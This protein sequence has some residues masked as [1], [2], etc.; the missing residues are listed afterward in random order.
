MRVVAI[1]TLGAVAAVGAAVAVAPVRD[2]RPSAAPQRVARPI[3]TP[4]AALPPA[5]PAEAPLVVR[6]I[7]DTGGPIRY[8]DW[9]WDEAGAPRQGRVIVTVDLVASTLSIF[10]EGYEIGTTAIIR[11]FEGKDTP[12]G[13]FPV[14][15][16]DADH[17]SRTYGDA[18]MPYTLR[19]TADGVSIHG[20][21]RIRYDS[22][23]HGCIGVPIAF[24]RKLFGA[25]AVGDVVIVTSGRS[26]DTGQP[27]T[28]T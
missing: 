18:P 20:S 10:R 14:L 25:V 5:A 8:G 4:R 21:D 13:R 24:A 19:L 27:I 22:A 26:L 23:T 2:E 6:R 15:L 12:L 1:L 16:K 7:L 9:F 11:G 17:R 3:A 28:R